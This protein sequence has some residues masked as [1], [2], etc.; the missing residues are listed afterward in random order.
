MI[1][2]T[3]LGTSPGPLLSFQEGGHYWVRVWND[4]SDRNT[5]IH[6]HGFTLYTTP[7]SDGT[8]MVSGW[9]IGP[10]AYFDYEIQLEDGFHGTF[11]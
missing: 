5:T 4:M 11:W 1:S 2:L 6:F 10:G 8:P 9:P 7:F 3:T